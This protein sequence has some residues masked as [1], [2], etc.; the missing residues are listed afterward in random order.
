MAV[1]HLILELRGEDKAGD[2]N[3]G[4]FS[5]EVLCKAAGLDE[6]TGNACTQQRRPRIEHKGTPS[7]KG[8]K[9]G[10]PASERG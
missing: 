2:V 4:V 7:F 1:E 5:R 6:I 8:W 3:F 10:D 9:E